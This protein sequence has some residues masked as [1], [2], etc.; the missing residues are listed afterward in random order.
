MLEWR[1]AHLCEGRLGETKTLE[2][3][4]HAIG[5]GTSRSDDPLHRLLSIGMRDVDD[6]HHAGP[7]RRRR[8]NRVQAHIGN[9]I[10][11]R[12]PQRHHVVIP[13]VP[14]RPGMDPGG[15]LGQPALVGDAIG[16]ATG[17][18]TD[19]PVRAEW[20]AASTIS[21]AARPSSS[22]DRQWRARFNGGR[23]LLD[24]SCR[25]RRFGAA[26]VDRPSSP[27]AGARA[28]CATRHRP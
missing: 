3:Q 16:P 18:P 19:S 24:L 8:Q 26:L 4:G 21:M 7:K 1:L 2:P 11:I 27:T 25:Q 10:S 17:I 9:P 28:P 6:G 22:G 23:G 13:Q 14:N 5:E 12:S 15:H 20:M